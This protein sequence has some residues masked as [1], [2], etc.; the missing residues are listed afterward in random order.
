MFAAETELEIPYTAAPPAMKG[1]LELREWE[2]GAV[3]RKLHPPTNRI[4]D[5]RWEKAATEIRLLWDENFLYLLFLCRDEAI[6]HLPAERDDSK[7]YLQDVCEVF[8]DAAGDARNYWEFQLN[9]GNVLFD[10]LIQLPGAP[11]YGADGRLTDEFFLN[12]VQRD[13]NRNLPGIIT[14]AGRT[15]NG[16]F[17]RWAVPAKPLTGRMFADGVRLRAQFCRY[18]YHFGEQIFSY[19]TRIL[20]GCPHTMP[21]HMGTL[22][23]KKQEK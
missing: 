6:L 12:R 22:Q 17:T 16:W 23:L 5:E 3:I 18:D 14:D 1:N 7:L 2:G 9:S 19:W 4:A 10:Q 21:G 20:N 15:G 13:A 8:L 11:E